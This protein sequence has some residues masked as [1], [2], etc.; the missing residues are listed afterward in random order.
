MKNDLDIRLK[1]QATPLIYCIVY[2]G[3]A[4]AISKLLNN[5]GS[6]ILD[7]RSLV[8]QLSMATITTTPYFELKLHVLEITCCY[9]KYYIHKTLQGT[10][11]IL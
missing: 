6:T 11:N 8:L 1:E 4:I 10:P 9:D 2:C 5:T 3:F 7:T